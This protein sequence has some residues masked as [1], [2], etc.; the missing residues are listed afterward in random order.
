MNILTHIIASI[1][2]RPIGLAV[3][4]VIMFVSTFITAVILYIY[5]YIMA[6]IFFH[7]GENWSSIENHQPSV[8]HIQS[9]S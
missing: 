2:A 6:V 3:K 4:L 8:C 7:G 1:T 5:I 9:F